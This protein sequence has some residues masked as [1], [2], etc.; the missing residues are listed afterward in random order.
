MKICTSRLGDEAGVICFGIEA[1]S[2]LEQHHM[3]EHS[4][5]NPSVSGYKMTESILR[6]HDDGD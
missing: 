5:P 2:S 4:A 1:Q 3:S 6:N